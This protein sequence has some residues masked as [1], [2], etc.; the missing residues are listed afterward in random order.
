IV[1]HSNRKG[2]HDLYTKPATGPGSEELLLTSAQDKRPLDWSPDGRF[3][4][5]ADTGPKG[6]VDILALP[7]DGDPK[8]F[9]VVQTNFDEDLAQFSPD[10]KWIA[11][12]A[13]ESG[14]YEIY[15]QPFPD[16][17]SHTQVST[18]G[19]AQARWRSD[20]KELF[21]IALDGRL[22]AV[23]IRIAS[24]SQTIEA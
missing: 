2:A 17:G 15:I 3:L 5:Y 4:L 11:Y 14:R 12:Q 18:N 24:S 7:M 20:G 16:P 19:G 13:N 10:G 22:M 8:P 23:P 6:G 1:F 9:P 21:Y